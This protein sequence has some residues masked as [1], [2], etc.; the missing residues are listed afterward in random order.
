MTT[1]NRNIKQKQQKPLKCIRHGFGQWTCEWILSWCC[2][3]ACQ[4]VGCGIYK[5]HCLWCFIY[6][7]EVKC[8]LNE[9]GLCHSTLSEYG[10]QNDFVQEVRQWGKNFLLHWKSFGDSV[11][12]AVIKHPCVTHY[13]PQTKYNW[14]WGK[15][16]IFITHPPR[17][18]SRPSSC[19]TWCSTCLQPSSALKLLYTPIPSN[20][21]LH[22]IH[23]GGGGT[24]AIF[25]LQ[26]L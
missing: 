13:L 25:L 22:S 7:C 9:S 23:W 21:Y 18:L 4:R 11:C 2:G 10:E 19:Q 8:R 20:H 5:S 15:T 6:L 26:G 16:I 24:D 1:D 3:L 12:K 17:S 14:H